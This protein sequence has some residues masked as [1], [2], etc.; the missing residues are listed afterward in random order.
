[1]SAP[2]RDTA[3][4]GTARAGTAPEPDRRAPGFGRSPVGAF[5]WAMSA[6]I[7]VA[8]L[9]SALGLNGVLRG[10]DWLVPAA[11]AVGAVVLTLAV[12]R[13][14][15]LP[16]AVVPVTALVVL[17][18]VLTLQFFPATALLGVLPTTS[19][20][21]EL[22]QLLGRTSETVVGGVAPVEAH[23][24][25]VL[26]TCAG[27][28]LVAV[29]V[30]ALAV[31]LGLAAASGLG[32]LA[33]LIVPAL[34]KLDSVGPWGFTGAAAGYLLVLACSQSLGAGRDLGT[35]DGPGSARPAGQGTRT[36]QAVG[37]GA[38]VIVLTLLLSAVLPGFT[39]GTFPEGSRFNPFGRSTGLNPMVTLGNDL[40]NPSGQG[41]MIYATDSSSPVYLR[42]TTLEDFDG[43]SW[44]PDERRGQRRF[45]PSR[46]TDDYS[47]AS[48]LDGV[49]TTTVVNSQEFNS[50]WLPVPYAPL[51]VQGLQ[52]RWTWDPETLS[53]R[54]ISSTTLH[55]TYTVRS[56]APKLTRESLAHVVTAPR[57]S[58][59]RQFLELPEGTPEIIRQ[60]A[61]DVT[62]TAPTPYDKAMA[63]Q[64][65]LRG[66]EFTY[67]ELTPLREGYDGSSMDVLAKFLEVK[68]GYCVHFAAAMAVM[69]REAGLPS[70]IAVGYAP[71]KITGNTVT[72]GGQE[73]TEF[74]VDGHNAHAWPELYFEGIGWVPFEPTPSRGQ[75]PGYALP[76]S[77]DLGA[78]SEP[79]ENLDPLA[80]SAPAGAASTAATGLGVAGGAGNDDGSALLRTLPVLLAGTALL[81]LLASPALTRVALRRRRHALLSPGPGRHQG[82]RAAEQPQVAAWAELLDLSRDFGVG[83]EPSETPRS[84]AAR[85]LGS[86]RLGTDMTDTDLRRAVDELLEGF[87]LSTYGRP[88][89][90]AD[91][92]DPA[93]HPAGLQLI[94]LHQAFRLQAAAG[95]RWR[96]LLLPPSTLNRWAG[97]FRQALP[98]RRGRQPFGQRLGKL[99]L[100][101][102]R[103]ARR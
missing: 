76:P 54:G 25:V 24:G 40:R 3:P 99:H 66:P 98:V 23:P 94:R 30:D 41:Q 101:G 20:L 63:I 69:A 81:G 15:R 36:V 33:V 56:V 61:L 70:R 72:V 16:E 62:G 75:V 73:L 57:Q 35:S 83:P 100:P 58:L 1:M 102:R 48:V 79:A 6:A 59:D 86:G 91:R 90:L 67:S 10:W 84:F 49:T 88:V 29:L 97:I 5:P 87:E 19:T 31:S 53:I 85:L 64:N 13:S 18:M 37:L 2:V 60:T 96:A 82:A 9:G 21:G 47:T 74:S 103:T 14:A 38:A 27:L 80:A 42:S 68:S 12:A 45:D 52:G 32:L 55:Q 93:R 8:V 77:D 89:Q 26:V 39:T 44:A 22:G 65:F 34:V 46:I 95:V 50:P 71:G 51:S 28:G 17:G 11:G 4:A 92:S 43:E 78:A 7:F